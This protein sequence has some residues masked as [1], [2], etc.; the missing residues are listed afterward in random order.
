M[1]RALLRLLGIVLSL[2]MFAAV[3]LTVRALRLPS[4]QITAPPAPVRVVDADAAA[5]RLAAAIRI[6]TISYSADAAD[7]QADAFAAFA[8]WLTESYPKL[9]ETLA[10]ERVSEH[11]LVYTWAGADPSLAPLVLLA[12]Q[13]VV[14][15]ENEELWSQPPFAGTIADGIVWG[16]GAVDDKGSL[17]AIC[18]AVETLLGEGFTPQRTVILAFGHDEEVG[19]PNGA[20]RVAETL[21]ARGV[22]AAL[23]LDEGFALLE[24]GT[25]PG[26]ERLVAPIGV[27][28][29]G[30]ATLQLVARAAG[31]HSSTPPR[32]TATVA[33]ARAVV[34]LDESP[35]PVS[36]GG[37]TGAF[38]HWLA[39]ELPLHLRVPLANLDVFARPL[40]WAAGG[41]P[42]INALLRTTTAVTMLS[43]SPKDNVLPVEATAAVN[44]RILP[45]QTA[46]EVLARTRQVVGNP[47]LE[48]RFQRAPRDPS[49]VSPSDGPAFTLLQRTLAELHPS[50][51][52]A[53]ALVVGGTDARHYTPIADAIYRF[54]PF[55]FGADDIKLPHGIDERIAVDNL[56]DGIRFY[57]RLIENASTIPGL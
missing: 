18:E 27:A 17:I 24:P 51:V 37:V 54:A 9:H 7:L 16:R 50:A 55:R 22:R 53:P 30:F 10:L 15:A 11:S 46:E 32:N 21:A 57:A 52:V 43:G 31:G 23:V 39:P 3:L 25:L 28:E 13:D 29:K 19:G 26:F 38:F 1:F 48:V 36:V 2:A 5:R 14:P 34:R 6:R 44:F 40:D 33:I 49:P 45:G 42:A 12:H 56:A 4:R 20:V 47:E 41:Q 8:R 35:M